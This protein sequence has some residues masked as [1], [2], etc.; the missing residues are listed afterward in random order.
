MIDIVIII[1]AVFWLSF[2]LISWAY[3]GYLLT[4]KIISLVYQ[5]KLVRQ[6]FTPDI[7]IV[8]T[9]YNEEKR[10]REKLDN[11][12]SLDYPPEKREI[13][14]VSDG[15]DDETE[16][17]VRTYIDKGVKL[18]AIPERHG[19]HYGQGEGIRQARN[20]IVVLSDATTFLKEDALRKIVRSFADPTIGCVSGEDR[21]KQ[22]GEG[23]DGEGI[24]VRYEMLLRSLESRV[25]SL[26]GVS[27]C[28]FAMRKKLVSD[29][30][31]DMSSDFYMPLVSRLHG[32]R[33]VLDSEA[34][35]IYRVLR[36]AEKEFIRKVRTV[37]HGFEVFFNFK[38]LLNPFKYGFYSVQ[39]L[40]H[41]L[42]RWLVPLWLFFMLVLNALLLDQGS[43]YQALMAGQLLFY[44]LALIGYLVKKSRDVF[45]FKIPLFFVMVNLSILVAWHYY[46][47]G[48]KFVTWDSTKR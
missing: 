40:S 3:F 26:V 5:K 37:V 11:T 38:K 13:I 28:F 29:W 2:F 44:L 32:Y 9:V 46:L 36:K 25:G 21:I 30:I 47:I 16:N 24:Y 6:D 23:S 17:I 33:A 41:K 14:I 48:K 7:S 1:K 8:I 15:S 43:L 20:D 4:L 10:I 18:L 45:V 27:G 42:G 12:L 39:L 35:G 22:D 31:D 34:I 19:K